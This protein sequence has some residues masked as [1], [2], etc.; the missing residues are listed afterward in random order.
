MSRDGRLVGFIRSGVLPTRVL[1][2][3]VQSDGH[4]TLGRDPEPRDPGRGRQSGVWD[5]S[6]TEGDREPE[7]QSLTQTRLSKFYT[8]LGLNRRSMEGCQR[9][10][11]H[12][13]VTSDRGRAERYTPNAHPPFRSGRASF[14]YNQHSS[15]GV[16]R[17]TKVYR[18]VTGTNQKVL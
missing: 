7:F 15:Q 9:N 14:P 16:A 3:P 2:S 13:E 18:A 8:T 17:T 6:T 4:R 10:H 1:L 12:T 5:L 11:T